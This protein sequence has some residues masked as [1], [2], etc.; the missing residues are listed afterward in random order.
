MGWGNTFEFD[1]K[2]LDLEIPK[3]GFRF[4]DQLLALIK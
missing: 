4:V 3:S 1:R 2:I